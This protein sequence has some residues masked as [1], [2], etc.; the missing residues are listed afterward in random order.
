MAHDEQTF[1]KTPFGVAAAVNAMYV[2]DGGIAK[3]VEEMYV[4]DPLAVGGYKLAFKPPHSDVEVTIVSLTQQA[5]VDQ[6]VLCIASTP[7]GELN[8]D[9]QIEFSLN[10]W[11]SI[12]NG[13]SNIWG[14]VRTFALDD[15]L[16][17]FKYRCVVTASDKGET[18]EDS[19]NGG[20]LQEACVGG[21]SS[22]WTDDNI[23]S[24]YVPTFSSDYE[25]I[26]FND[27]YP[28]VTTTT[29][30]RNAFPLI[31][32]NTDASTATT[33]P[34]VALYFPTGW[35][36]FGPKSASNGSHSYS[37]L[38]WPTGES[39]T[40][41]NVDEIVP[42]ALLNK[43]DGAEGSGGTDS[44]TYPG[45]LIPEP[46]GGLLQ[47]MHWKML[48]DSSADITYSG[49]RELLPDEAGIFSAGLEII[50]PNIDTSLSIGGGPRFWNG[51]EA[52][53]YGAQLS[54]AKYRFGSGAESKA[55]W[56][57]NYQARVR[58]NGGTWLIADDEDDIG[59][60]Y[61]GGSSGDYNNCGQ[62]AGLKW[63][64]PMERP[65]EAGDDLDIEVY[66]KGQLP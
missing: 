50:N 36:V 24:G 17:G 66:A 16:I 58:L 63:P 13:P 42:V 60:I 46:T 6:E 62:N 52:E 39:G 40:A 1:I 61:V 2:K 15:S 37:P 49:S 5:C 48:T 8:Y 64:V 45:E 30:L 51:P 33:A 31:R 14:N 53:N 32:S 9:F 26:I 55:W 47:V 59:T 3:Y 28:N 44:W 65:L 23:G 19:I 27:S 21:E 38:A 12:Q 11:L 41:P 57:D 10:N 43:Y 35:H 54:G 56:R 20:R 7:R 34:Y 4:A 29:A 25:N 18:D 22:D